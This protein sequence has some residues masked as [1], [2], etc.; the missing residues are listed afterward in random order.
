MSHIAMTSPLCFSM[1]IPLHAP[2]LT[3]KL[4]VSLFVLPYSFAI[5]KSLINATYIHHH[6]PVIVILAPNLEKTLNLLLR[7]FRD[8]LAGWLGEII[9]PFIHTLHITWLRFLLL[10]LGINT[11][12]PNTFFWQ[13]CSDNC[14]KPKYHHIGHFVSFKFIPK[15]V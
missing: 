13:S 14:S 9:L 6:S 4:Q 5:Y 2:Y 15:H 12:S 1:P 10:P 3:V 11:R 8:C 7:Y